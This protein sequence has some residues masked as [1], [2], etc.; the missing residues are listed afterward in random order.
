MGFVVVVPVIAAAVWVLAR[1]GIG[2]VG[3]SYQRIIGFVSAFA[4]VP[5]I[6]TAGGVGRLAAHASVKLRGGGLLG[7]IRAGALAFAA[8]GIGLVLL[9]AIPLGGLPPD[10][11]RWLWLALAGAVA[12]VAAGA[13]IGLWAGYR[14]TG[15]RA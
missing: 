15:G 8:A 7:S 3:A 6:L 5:A 4:G 13:V 12:G 14:E 1:F 2:D 9:T 10:P 11:R